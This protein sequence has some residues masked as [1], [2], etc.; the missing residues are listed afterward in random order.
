[1][2]VWHQK[3]DQFIEQI[4]VKHQ[5]TV[6]NFK[7]SLKVSVT[8][9]EKLFRWITYGVLYSIAPLIITVSF[10]VLFGYVIRVAD[11]LTDFLFALFAVSMNLVNLISDDADCS[12]FNQFVRSFVALIALMSFQLP[13]LLLF[14]PATTYSVLSRAILVN[15]STFLTQKATI[16]MIFRV[17]AFFMIVV[18]ALGIFIIVRQNSKHIDISD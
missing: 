11:F 16:N 5:Q 12:D 10:S 3:K 14:M 6:R 1:M 4:I 7:S 13:I 18:I 9:K 17:S 8:L 2:W 15:I